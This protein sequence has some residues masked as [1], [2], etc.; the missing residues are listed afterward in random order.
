MVTEAIT[1]MA[2]SDSTCT[3]VFSSVNMSCTAIGLLS[4]F[5]AENVY[6]VTSL[7]HPTE[8]NFCDRAG[9]RFS[10]LKSHVLFRFL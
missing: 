5:E 2:T 9:I 3:H 1:V 8:Q 7:L 4:E 6:I 10:N